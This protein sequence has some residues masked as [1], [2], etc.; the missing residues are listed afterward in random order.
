MALRLVSV[1]RRAGL[2]KLGCAWI[3]VHLELVSTQTHRH[4]NA[5]SLLRVH[6]WFQ[7]RVWCKIPRPLISFSLAQSLELLGSVSFID[8]FENILTL[9][10]KF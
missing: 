1:G 5:Q 9:V 4:T 2:G 10:F 6:S 3:T 8:R 7:A